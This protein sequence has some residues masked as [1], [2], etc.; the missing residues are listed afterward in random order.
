[1]A[2]ELANLKVGAEFNIQNQTLKLTDLIAG[3]YNTKHGLTLTNIKG[4]FKVIGSSGDVL[5]ENIG[6][7]TE[8]YASPDTNGV[9]PTWGIDGIVLPL[10]SNGTILN[11]VYTIEYLVSTAGTDETD[12][13]FSK[14]FTF[15]YN[16]PAGVINGEANITSSYA[17]ITDQTVYNAFVNSV[18]YAPDNLASRL[19]TIRW[20]VG[21]GESDITTNLDSRVIGPNIWTGE[22][23]LILSTS[24]V[25]SIPEDDYLTV[26]FVDVISDT[27]SMS[28]AINDCASTVETCMVA[29]TA[30]YE[31]AKLYNLPEAQVLKKNLSDI[32]MYYDMYQMAVLT[33]KDT[34]YSCTILRELMVKNG[35]EAQ[36]ETATS[37]EIIPA[38]S[39][40]SGK[41]E[42]IV[43][44]SS[45][46]AF[47][48]NFVLTTTSLVLVDGVALINSQVNS[49]SF[50]TTTLTLLA[51]TT[52]GQTV[53]VFE[54]L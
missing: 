47:S 37:R 38:T 27:S 14:A 33:S 25:Y 9:T 11:D 17:T 21:S 10:N 34:T 43:T 45:Q 51:P 36:A 54:N 4:L 31:Q 22:Y 32:V 7:A 42:F 52:A 39:T 49:S 44:A 28:A 48:L 19:M 8:S 40:S 30:Q 16:T 3:E 29:L 35:C 24:V 12:F 6:F 46:I 18:F 53:I 26:S 5:Y 23:S 15:D 1:M 20:P 2:L 50:G 41:Q 13:S